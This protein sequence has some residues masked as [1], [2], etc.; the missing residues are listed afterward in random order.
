MSFITF[1]I[2]ITSVVS[3]ID[4]QHMFILS[5]FPVVIGTVIIIFPE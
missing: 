1:I 3:K 2:E 4:V 5:D